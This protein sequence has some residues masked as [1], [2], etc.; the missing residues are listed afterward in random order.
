[1]RSRLLTLILLLSA[2]AATGC[3][4]RATPPDHASRA[5]HVALA[6]YQG[7]RDSY[8][9]FPYG[10]APLVYGPDAASR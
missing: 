10:P 9:A 5:D 4:A 2:G 6:R 3:A 7:I 1:M 8:G